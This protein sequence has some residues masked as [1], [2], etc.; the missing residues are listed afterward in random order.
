MAYIESAF[1]AICRDAQEPDEWY[2]LLIESFQAYG[3][4]QEGGW[5]YTIQTVKA[6]QQFPAR[7]LAKRAAA[8]VENLAKELDKEARD[9]HGEY[10]LRQ[11]DWLDARGLD[12]DFLPE[13][14][15][16]SEFRVVI[17]REI[18]QFDNCRPCYC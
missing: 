16:P 3:G 7:I 10:C 2:V 4:P 5:W 9:Q 14:D 11:M 8:A 17:A 1:N 6:Y 18:P 12:A 13:N 15:G